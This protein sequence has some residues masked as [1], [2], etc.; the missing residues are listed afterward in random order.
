VLV[1]KYAN[2]R[3]YDTQESRYITL[4]ELAGR[5]RDGA[6]ARVVDAATGEDL[7]QATLAQIILEGR[8]AAQLLPI[9]L[10]TQLIRMG[11]DALA[12]FFGRY[13]TSALELYVQARQGAQALAPYNP[14]ATSPFA[15]TSA[16]ARFFMNAG[17][18]SPGFGGFGWGEGQRQAP[19]PSPPPEAPSAP[20]AD[21]DVK[22]LR[23]ELEELK[24]VVR[25]AQATAPKKPTRRA[26]K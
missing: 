22:D 20:G 11:D 19:P 5:I 8:R 6:E 24:R 23:R 12:E 7:T 26:A 16:L 3:L 25:G 13:L 14:F 2:R 15:A 9:P 17:L 21:E 4:E 10:L 1:K 18:P